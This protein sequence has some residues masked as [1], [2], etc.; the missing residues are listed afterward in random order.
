MVSLDDE[1]GLDECLFDIEKLSLD[2]IKSFV[3]LPS[4]A[5]LIILAVVRFV[6]D[7]LDRLEKRF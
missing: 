3:N 6:L 4:R 2:V 5:R 1:S 7:V